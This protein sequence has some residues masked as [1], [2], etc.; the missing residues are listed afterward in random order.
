MSNGNGNNGSTH[1]GEP[2]DGWT[3]LSGQSSGR[4]CPAGHGWLAQQVQLPALMVA[5]ADM[6]RVWPDW[7]SVKAAV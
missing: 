5:C 4:G 7:V 3:P 6:V 1:G 2:D